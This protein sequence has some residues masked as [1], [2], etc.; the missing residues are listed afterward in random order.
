MGI[1]RVNIDVGDSQGERYESVAA[2]VDIGA[3]YTTMP[4]S[5]LRGLGVVP[6]D[7]AEF[8]LAD[9]NVSKAGYRTHLGT[10]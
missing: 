8:E 3:T 7:R 10:D 1:F 4:A 5:I 2:L 9:G 6:H